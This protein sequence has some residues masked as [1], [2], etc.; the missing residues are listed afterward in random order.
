MFFMVTGGMI[1][2][3]ERFGQIVDDAGDDIIGDIQLYNT[4]K[5]VLNDNYMEII[6]VNDIIPVIYYFAS[7][8]AEDDLIKVLSEVK[9]YCTDNTIEFEHG[10]EAS[11]DSPEEASDDAPEEDEAEE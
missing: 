4:Q 2:L 7:E 11:D 3:L 10:E 5:V 9:S 1:F 6:A 8:L